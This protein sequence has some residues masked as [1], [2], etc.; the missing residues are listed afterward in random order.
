MQRAMYVALGKIGTPDAVR[1]LIT[2]ANDSGSIFRRGRTPIRVAAV[3]GLVE[4]QTPEA[5]AAI[6]GLTNDRDR[7]VRDSAEKGL[8]ARKREDGKQTPHRGW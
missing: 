3:K 2:T 4:A 7:E 6:K 1:K 5:V 8:T